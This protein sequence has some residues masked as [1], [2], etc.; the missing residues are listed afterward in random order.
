MCVCGSVRTD[1]R[2][3]REQDASSRSFRQ[4]STVMSSSVHPNHLERRQVLLLHYSA[5]GCLGA[6]CFVLFCLKMRFV[7]NGRAGQRGPNALRKFFFLLRLSSVAVF[8]LE[9]HLKLVWPP[10]A[11][12][13]LRLGSS[14]AWRLMSALD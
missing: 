11:A 10:A 5:D 9:E 14:P 4:R 13:R 12:G 8:R 1:G 3:N 6:R 2:I 7:F